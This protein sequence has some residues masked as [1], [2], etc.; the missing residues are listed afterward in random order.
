MLDVTLLELCG[1]DNKKGETRTHIVDGTYKIKKVGYCMYAVIC[2]DRHGYE[3][4]MALEFL[5]NEQDDNILFFVQAVKE[6]LPGW[7]R[8]EVGFVDKDF[9]QIKVLRKELPQTQIL[10]YVLHAIN[11][12]KAKIGWLLSQK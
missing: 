8:V 3:Q 5:A 11:W 10:L 4:P 7:N 12:L 2:E 9:Q 1:A 6:I